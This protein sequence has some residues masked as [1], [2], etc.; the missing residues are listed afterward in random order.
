MKRGNAISLISQIREK[1]NRFIIRELEKRGINGIVPSHGDIFGVLFRTEQST[2]TELAEAIRR[3]KPTVTVL[4]DKLVDLGYVVKEKSST[5]N[6]VTY[7]KLTQEGLDLKPSFQEI[8]VA[9]KAMVYRGMSEEE[10]EQ[11]EKTLQS[12]LGHLDEDV[13]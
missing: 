13:E 5:D 11:F 4:I 6:R 2:M 10:S 7:I 9:L 8:S 1:A 12:V 3:T